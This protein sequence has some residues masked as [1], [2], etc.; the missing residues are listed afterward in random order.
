MVAVMVFSVAWTFAMLAGG[1][2]IGWALLLGFGLALLIGIANGIL[3]AYVDARRLVHD[4][5]PL[6]ARDHGVRVFGKALSAPGM[7]ERPSAHPRRF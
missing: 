3:I 1:M 4:R 2:P 7:K 5:Q 6:R